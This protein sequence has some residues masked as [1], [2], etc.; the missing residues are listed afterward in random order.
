LSVFYAELRQYKFPK[1]LPRASSAGVSG[2]SGII[3]AEGARAML[4]NQ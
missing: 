3:Q 2:V 1:I 4:I